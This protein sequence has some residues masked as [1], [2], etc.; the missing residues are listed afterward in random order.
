MG[1]HK[2]T[3]GRMALPLAMALCVLLAF[4]CSSPAPAPT[5]APAKQD[6]PAAPTAAAK[7]AAPEAT[8][9]A[10]KAAA[11]GEK[12]PSRPIDYIV[13]WGAGGGADQMSR[14]IG[15]LAEK[16]LGVALPAINVAGATGGTGA[17]KMLAAP[18]DGYTIMTFIADSLANVAS[19]AAA[20]SHKDFAPIVRTQLCPSFFFVKGDSPYETW[21]DLEKAAKDNPDSLRV[22]IT[23][24]GSLDEVT[25]AYFA[26][27]GIKMNP[28]PYPNPGERYAA[29]LGGHVEVLYEQAGDVRQY[30]TN[31]EMKPL[32]IFAEERLPAFPD[33][34]AS[35][36]LGYE[37]YLP[38]FRSIVAKAGTDPDR[39]K[40]LADAFEKATKTP[41]WAEFAKQQHMTDD[42]F[43]GPDEFTKFMNGEYDTLITLMQDL[44]LKS[45]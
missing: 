33:V 14:L 15:S 24:E 28:V 16:D 42:S 10:E 20:Y 23:G 35:K 32:I 13:P 37:I 43:M 21:A 11:T 12:Y 6:A 40:I 5:A 2:L 30:I 31:K 17:A 44:G 38:Q 41:E 4:G 22:G 9:P 39:I 34:V 29:L 25:V 1:L 19:G 27:K 7:A 18:A 26:S 36:E 8:K 3:R 45:Q